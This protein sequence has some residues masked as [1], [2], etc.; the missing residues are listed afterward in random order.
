MAAFNRINKLRFFQILRPHLGEE[1]AE[2]FSD[3]LEDE[4]SPLATKSDLDRLR[5]S[6]RGDQQKFLLWATAAWAALLAA[7]VAIAQLF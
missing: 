4:F 2:Q 6:L 3:A 7:A 1:A 5:D